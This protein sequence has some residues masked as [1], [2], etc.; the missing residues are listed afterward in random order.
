MTSSK[1]C[2][3][4]KR[5]W[6]LSDFSRRANGTANAW[7]KACHREYD[8]LYYRADPARYTRIA[9]ERERKLR[10]FVAELK[11]NKTCPDCGRIFPHF[12]L[13]FDHVQGTKAF[14]LPHIYTRHISI[15]RVLQEI[16]KCELVCSNC[17]RRRTFTR[18]CV[19]TGGAAGKR[20]RRTASA[21]LRAF[22]IR[23][24][25]ADCGLRHPYFVLDF[26]HT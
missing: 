10:Y 26:D 14:I 22:K 7:C 21:V 20:I 17:H 5:T 24:R 25:C 15:A 12:L 23:S 11:H 13:D 4:C 9:R 19:R 1:C 16:E 2:S 18:K 3:R 6:P 8:K